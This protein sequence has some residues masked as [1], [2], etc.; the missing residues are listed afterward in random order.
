M[1]KFSRSGKPH[2]IYQDFGF[3][4]AGMREKI[5]ASLK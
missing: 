1:S 3:H 2:E 4:P 5:L